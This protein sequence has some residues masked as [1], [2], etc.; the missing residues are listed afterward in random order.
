MSHERTILAWHAKSHREHTRS[1]D[2]YIAIGLISISLIGLSLVSRNFLFTIFIIIATFVFVLESARP[3]K[4]LSFFI[5]RR[6]IRREKQLFPYQNLESFWIREEEDGY[7][8]LAVRSQ[9]IL[10]SRIVFPLSQEVPEEDIREVLSQFLPEIP[11]EK[12]SLEQLS[13]FLGF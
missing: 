13:D 11:D 9:H 12:S 7:R 6:G 5:E 4:M 2:W 1:R 3:A 10:A 8:E